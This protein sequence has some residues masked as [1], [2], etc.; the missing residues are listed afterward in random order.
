MAP[1]NNEK[2]RIEQQGAHQYESGNQ[3]II[4]LNRRFVEQQEE[5]EKLRDTVREHSEQ[6]SGNNDRELLKNCVFTRLE[7]H[8]K[9]HED[10]ALIFSR[11]FK[12]AAWFGATI[13]ALLAHTIW[14]YV[15][16]KP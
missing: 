13:G 11:G 5:I 14:K 6:L 7:G 12:F 15:T 8:D 10:A 1:G 2:G 16:G 3:Q 4:D 9:K